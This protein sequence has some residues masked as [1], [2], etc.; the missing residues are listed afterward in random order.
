MNRLEH[1]YPVY[2]TNPSVRTEIE[3]LPSLAEFPTA[4]RISEVVAHLE[5]LMWRINPKFYGATEP[6]LWLIAKIPS[7]TLVNC[8]VTSESKP[9]THSYD[10]L[11]DL[12]IGLAMERGKDSPMGKYVHK[13]LRRKTP[14]EKS[15][16]GSLPRRHS[17]PRIGRGAQLEHMKETPPP[18]VKGPKSFLLSSYR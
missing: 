11:V 15:C 3:E 10:D 6:Q 7:K 9:R 5:E 1:M 2:E 16:G 8:R 13:H 18:M 4:A 14:V 12:Y 17:K